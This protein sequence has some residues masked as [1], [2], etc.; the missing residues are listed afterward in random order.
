MKNLVLLFFIIPSIVVS[1]QSAPVCTQLKEGIF[2]V[3]PRNTTDQYK[4]VRTKDKQVEHNLKT[5]E[6]T[7][8][9]VT[10][11]SNCQYILAHISS[12]AKK[13]GADL[14][15][16]YKLA[17]EVVS[18]ASGYY[19][20]NMYLDKVNPGDIEYRQISTDT[21]WL[22]PLNIPANQQLFQ[23]LTEKPEHLK[24]HFNDTSSYAIVYIYRPNK[25]PASINEYYIY[26]N[27][28][29]LFWVRNK[30]KT[31]YKIYRQGPV[32]FHAK[33]GKVETSV[34]LD[35]E[36]GRKYYLECLMHPK[37]PYAIP[38][39]RLEEPTDGQIGWNLL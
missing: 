35:I 26:L 32:T 29:F 13:P 10:W 20:Y 24:T 34:T 30:A 27:Q 36:F 3:Y 19:V 17:Y 14:I 21:A 9:Q 6:V 33:S 5:G 18:V 4:I 25:A 39:I 38:E 12:T 23:V 22:K 16:K 11:N 1:Q 7:E 37:T 8:Y 15:K 28:D 31:A 2:Y